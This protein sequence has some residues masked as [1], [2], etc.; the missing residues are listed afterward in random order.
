MVKPLI[1]RFVGVFHCLLVAMSVKSHANGALFV[2][3][4]PGYFLSKRVFLKLLNLKKS[5]CFLEIAQLP[6]AKRLVNPTN[7]LAN[8]CWQ[9]ICLK[10]YLFGEKKCSISK[11]ILHLLVLIEVVSVLL[12]AHAKRFIVSRMRDLLLT[13][14]ICNRDPSNEQSVFF[15][16]VIFRNIWI[17]HKCPFHIFSQSRGGTTS[18]MECICKKKKEHSKMFGI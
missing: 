3:E 1:C 11:K 18:F 16:L 15:C 7:T 14:L 13:L 10:N 12:S 5:F 17:G 6:Q 4:P 2:M 9:K 8:K